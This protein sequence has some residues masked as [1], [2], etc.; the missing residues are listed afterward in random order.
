[1]A[2]N[3]ENTNSTYELKTANI[4][5]AGK[6]GTG[7]STLLNAVFGEELAETG[8]GRPVTDHITEYEHEDIPIHIW[9]TVGL[10]LDSEKTNQSI[11][12]IKNTI[13]SKSDSKNSLDQIHAIWYCI[14][15]GS[16]RYE[17]AELNFIK[18]LYSIGVPFT[19][20]MTQ[21]YGKKEKISKF[22]EIIKKTNAEMGL[23]N[24]PIIRVIAQD[25]EFEINDDIVTIPAFGLDV[26]VDSTME[27]L[28]SYIQSGFIAAQRV[29][30]SLKHSECE[31]LIWDYIVK[32]QDNY[33][34]KF[35][36]INWDNVP[37]INCLT[38]DGHVRDLFE[39]ISK[40]YNSA[41]PE[42]S[43]NTI[44]Q[45]LGHISSE[46]ALQALIKFK[47]PEAFNDKIKEKYSANANGEF[48]DDYSKL[49]TNMRVSRLIILYGYT[50]LEAIEEL[51][52][53]IQRGEEKDLEQRVK[54]LVQSIREKV[55]KVYNSSR[56]DQI[57]LETR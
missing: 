31:K 39:D 11:S 19:I 50:F 14:N 36:I 1:M 38:A 54:D 33:W 18:E 27:Q 16:N 57:R 5:V 53:A 45:N 47:V 25:Y 42:E 4:M 32:I 9:D 15:T 37:L 44:L 20:V 8:T 29:N 28:P 55:Y 17:G 52:E 43:L 24:V 2:E 48:D 3:A 34:S 6:T 46:I 35:K 30:E 13:A 56:T 22:E 26:L 7:K 49:S 21:C 10:L 23:D 40:I 41:V 12:E 51:W